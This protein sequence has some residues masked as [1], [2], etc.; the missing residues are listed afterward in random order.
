VS[1]GCTP[2][3]SP[4][5]AAGGLGAASGTA[6]RLSLLGVIAACILAAG[7]AQPLDSSA[8]SVPTDQE[9]QSLCLGSRPYGTGAVRYWRALNDHQVACLV[10]YPTATCFLY[11]VWWYGLWTGPQAIRQQF[12]AGGTPDC[13]AGAATKRL[14]PGKP[15]QLSGMLTMPDGAPLANASLFVTV[16]NDAVGGTDLDAIG[17]TAQRL[18]GLKTGH[19]GRYSF[20]LGPGPSR[21]VFI[22][23]RT[24]TGFATAG[25]LVRVRP[26]VRLRASSRYLLNGE[27]L[28]L[29]GTIGGPV[30]ARG[31][32][33][34]L[35][36]HS[37]PKW[38]TFGSAR[39][40]PTRR[41]N[42]RFRF[43]YRFRNTTATT[44]YRFRALITAQPAYPYAKGASKAV[45]V[46]VIA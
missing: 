12:G 7:A 32:R 1:E 8:R 18:S 35:Q 40:R 13:F 39:A 14:R 29:V 9:A 30:P 33:L 41:G 37:G 3:D 19:D 10:N 44:A 38:Q 17:F 45:K 16:Q 23:A 27:R 22:V 5:R 25:R 6:R 21:R 15:A 4:G 24:S 26:R 42:G 34:E 20:E 11:E 46:T 43:T 2:V 28:A 31:V 36:H